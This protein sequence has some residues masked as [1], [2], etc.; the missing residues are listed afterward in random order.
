M[1]RTN[2]Y[3]SVYEGFKTGYFIIIGYF[4]SSIDYF[5]VAIGLSVNGNF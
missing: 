5:S 4:A 3:G 1:A 2:N